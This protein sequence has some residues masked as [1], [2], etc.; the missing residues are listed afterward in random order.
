MCVCVSIINLQSDEWHNEHRC[1][2]Q[3]CFDAHDIRRGVAL[4]KLDSSNVSRP[5]AAAN[6]SFFTLVEMTGSHRIFALKSAGKLI[7]VVFLSDG[8]RLT[9]QLHW[10]QSVV[11]RLQQQHQLLLLLLLHRLRQQKDCCCIWYLSEAISTTVH[12]CGCRAA[13]I[14]MMPAGYRVFAS[15]KY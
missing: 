12:V 9:G 4:V 13:N 5:A 14:A 11:Q 15:I 6:A 7:P 1:L 2:L 3:I 10:L 8:L